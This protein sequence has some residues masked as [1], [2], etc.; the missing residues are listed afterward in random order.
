MS[1]HN[2]LFRQVHLDFH[3]SAQCQGV[4]IQFEPD[5]FVATLKLEFKNGSE[6]EIK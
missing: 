5:E 3:T 2:Q 6:Q 1:P 4:G